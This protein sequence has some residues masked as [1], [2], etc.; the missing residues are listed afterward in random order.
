MKLQAEFYTNQI[1][2]LETESLDY[3]LDSCIRN[4]FDI[5]L[6]ERDKMKISR[7]KKNNVSNR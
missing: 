4:S 6:E 5:H 2:A 1:Q 7:E 3:A